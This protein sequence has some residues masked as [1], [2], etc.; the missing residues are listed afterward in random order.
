MAVK[1]YDRAF[2]VMTLGSVVCFIS[3]LGLLLYF[4]RENEVTYSCKILFVTVLCYIV[5]M[6]GLLMGVSVYYDGDSFMFSKIDAFYY[7]NHSKEFASLGFVK[8]F[9]YITQN[10][11]YDDWGRCCLTAY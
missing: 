1:V 9:K 5:L 2:S 10:F 6:G 7:M 4:S 8:G 11:D 3:Q